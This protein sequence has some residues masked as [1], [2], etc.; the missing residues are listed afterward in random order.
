MVFRRCGVVSVI[1]TPSSYGIVLVVCTLSSLK[2]SA[3]ISCRKNSL[4]SKVNADCHATEFIS[5]G[6]MVDT[7]L[8]VR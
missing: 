4:V 6:G 1:C 3:C 5:M 8:C 2:L 7:G